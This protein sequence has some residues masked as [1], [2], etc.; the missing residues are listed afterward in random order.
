MHPVEVELKAQV[1]NVERTIIEPCNHNQ[2]ESPLLAGSEHIGAHTPNCGMSTD[3]ISKFG[4]S[5]I[6]F[7]NLFK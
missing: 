1:L 5:L 3:N 6:T 4:I 2:D 7:S